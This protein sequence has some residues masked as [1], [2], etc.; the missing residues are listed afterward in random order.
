MFL[1]FI[2]VI[3]ESIKSHFRWEKY[4]YTNYKPGQKAMPVKVRFIKRQG[5]DE[6]DVREKTIDNSSGVII[7]TSNGIVHCKKNWI[8]GKSYVGEHL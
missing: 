2:Q 7:T 4:S 8:T 6:V 5:E 1:L 3:N